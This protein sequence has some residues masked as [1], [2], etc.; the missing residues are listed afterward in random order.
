M[1]VKDDCSTTVT[2]TNWKGRKALAEGRQSQ[3]KNES[4]VHPIVAM[5]APE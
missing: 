4:A 2:H 5:V 3:S 1:V